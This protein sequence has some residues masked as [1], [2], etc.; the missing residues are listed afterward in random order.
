M[1]KGLRIKSEIKNERMRAD[2]Y[3]PNIMGGMYYNIHINSE[4]Q[5]W[6]VDIGMEVESQKEGGLSSNG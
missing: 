6:R 4:E 2:H 1:G 5:E 3:G